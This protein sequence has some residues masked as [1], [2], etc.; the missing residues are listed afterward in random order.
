MFKGLKGKQED[1]C[2]VNNTEHF[3]CIVMGTLTQDLKSKW[4][5]MASTMINNCTLSFFFYMI[6]T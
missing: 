1:I 3:T 4:Y 6:Y 5:F 2:I